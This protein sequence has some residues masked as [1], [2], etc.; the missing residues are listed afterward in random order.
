[1]ALQSFALGLVAAFTLGTA[2]FIAAFV[3]RRIGVTRLLVV[4]HVAAVGFATPFVLFGANLSEIPLLCLPAIAAVSLLFV[5]AAASFYKGLQLSPIALVSPIV[6]SHLV[7]VILLSVLLLGERLGPMQMMGITAAVGGTIA[8][9]V[10]MGGSHQHSF[11]SSKGKWFYLASTLCSGFF[12]F[13]IGA[14]S[15]EVGWFLTVYLVRLFTLF[16]LLIALKAVPNLEWRTLS[17]KN[18]GMAALVGVLICF[19]LGAYAMGTQIG[20]ISITATAFSAYPIVPIVGGVI[21]FRERL[22]SRQ[23]LGLASVLAGL[24]VLSISS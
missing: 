15:R 5:A 8:A 3:V 16:L 7:I 6:S 22:V 13:A 19:G 10:T 2:D 11:Q 14:L 20:P 12:V 9:S 4:S 18:A 23:I 17:V 24:L 21:I 1:V